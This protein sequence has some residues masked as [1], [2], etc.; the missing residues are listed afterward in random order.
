MGRSQGEARRSWD[1]IIT[2]RQLR[3]RAR[4]PLDLD[5][6][7]VPGSVRY[8]PAMQSPTHNLTRR[9]LVLSLLLPVLLVA[10]PLHAQSPSRQAAASGDEA[11]LLTLLDE[12][13][14][15]AGLDDQEMHDRFWADDL[16]Y[17]AASGDR[18]GKAAILQG[19]DPQA[20]D[21]GAAQVRYWA[22]DAQVMLFGDTAVV[23]FRL[24]AETRSA[25]G[26]ET[27]QEQ[28]HNTGTFVRRNG[29]WRAV[30]WQATRI[31]AT[32]NPG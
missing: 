5:G 2:P 6:L 10:G 8:T 24:M 4:R 1:R 21:P 26:A 11:E 30:A 9:L 14:A 20:S 17:T 12:F 19:L 15:Q 27:V 32:A 23:A 31:P 25:P 16:V 7:P 18:F 3:W 28:F 22:E 29:E 13:L